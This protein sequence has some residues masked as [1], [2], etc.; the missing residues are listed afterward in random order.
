MFVHVQ[1][2]LVE[3][4]LGPWPNGLDELYFLS[5]KEFHTRGNV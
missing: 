3:L 2:K 4:Y 1:I 5:N